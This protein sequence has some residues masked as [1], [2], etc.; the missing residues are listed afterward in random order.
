M[1]ERYSTPPHIPKA[2]LA[3]FG[4]QKFCL[5]PASPN[6][7][8]IPCRKFFTEDDDGLSQPWYGSLVFLNPPYVALQRWIDKAVYEHKIGRAAKIVMLL[9]T[10]FG[11][12]GLQAM[13][14]LGDK[15]AELLLLDK[16]LRF[17]QHRY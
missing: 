3:A 4:W 6:P 7:P 14:R 17:G 16:Q 11:H 5:D 9:P 2:I 8:T 12:L 13:R 10:G 1:V 15:G